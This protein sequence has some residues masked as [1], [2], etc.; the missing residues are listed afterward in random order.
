L[1]EKKADK[2]GSAS[3]T[4]GFIPSG[5]SCQLHGRILCSS[6]IVVPFRRSL[7]VAGR[8]PDNPRAIVDIAEPLGIA[9][10]DH[11][12]VGRNRHAS[13]KG[14]RLIYLSPA[15]TIY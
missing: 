6:V 2:C 12:I 8:H 10:H 15:F 4:G 1:S 3:T 13:L 5:R 11:I 9:V 14:M 7:A